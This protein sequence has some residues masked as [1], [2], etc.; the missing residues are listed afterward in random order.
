MRNPSGILITDTW[1]LRTTPKQGA[2]KDRNLGMEDSITMMDTAIIVTMTSTAEATTT[3]QEGAAAT[4][5]RAAEAVV[6][7]MG[8]TM[9]TTTTTMVDVSRIRDNKMG[10][11]STAVTLP[12][13]SV[14]V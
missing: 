14:M 9:V 11:I 12:S 7:G 5:D 10:A 2:S 3:A 1:V 8:G 13:L 6:M 4:T